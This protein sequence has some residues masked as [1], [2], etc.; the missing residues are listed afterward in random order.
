VV[1]VHA[2]EDVAILTF[3]EMLDAVA[4]YLDALWRADDAEDL[5]NWD[6]DAE[7]DRGR[8]LTGLRFLDI[9]LATG[10]LLRARADGWKQ[11]CERL[12]VPPF[13]LWEL[14]PGYKRLQI[15]LDMAEDSPDSPGAAFAPEGMLAWLN[16]VR[17]AG[18]AEIHD[19]VPTP[20]WYANGAEEC[21][22]ERAKWW[23]S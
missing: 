16:E 19:L 6:D 17:P 9:A 1:F 12:G 5:R 10:Y 21:Y 3:I 13:A 15:A 20:E 14:L 11:F 8:R 23:G 4:G 2:F 18:D 22:R 7:A